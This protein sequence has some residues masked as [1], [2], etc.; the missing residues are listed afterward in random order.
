MQHAQFSVPSGK[1]EHRTLKFLIRLNFSCYDVFFCSCTSI[2]VTRSLIQLALMYFPTQLSQTTHQKQS[3]KTNKG[4]LID[5][6][7][8]IELNKK[9]KSPTKKLCLLLCQIICIFFAGKIILPFKSN[10]SPK[11]FEPISLVEA[12]ARFILR[13]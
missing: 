10:S 8:W 12:G 5:L 6:S 11:R 2:K 13:K 4:N 3:F 7:K 1:I 9:F